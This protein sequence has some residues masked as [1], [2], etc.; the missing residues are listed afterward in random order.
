MIRS[1]LNLRQR[2]PA[3]FFSHA[4]VG[5]GIVGLAVGAE[6][7][8]N[9]AHSVIIIEKNQ[10]LCQETSS[11]NSEVIH[12]GIYYPPESLKSRSCIEGKN[13]LYSKSEHLELRRCGKYIVAQSAEQCEYLHK[14]HGLMHERVPLQMIGKQ[15]LQREQPL[16]QGASA[17]KSPSTGI[18][19]AHS[20]MN[21]LESSFQ[22]H[23][24]EIALESRVTAIEYKA[25]QE[26]TIEVTAVDGETVSLDVNNI[27]NAAGLFACQVSNLV[28]GK[29]RQIQPFYARG[30]YYTVDAPVKIDTLIYP[31]PTPGITGLGTHLTIDMGGQ[32][33]FGPDVEWTSDPND[34]KLRSAPKDIAKDVSTYMPSLANCNFNPTM[35]GIRPKLKKEREFQDFVIKQEMPGFFN[36]L[37]I[38]SPG[39]T[40]SMA[41]GKYVSKMAT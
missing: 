1:H 27:I 19:S 40:A 28:L 10:Q 8:K 30:N 26:Y 21:F 31:C 25:P 39:L 11:R 14:V 9:S 7:A 2:N 24:G 37:G 34:Y 13:L 32:V 15:Q 16:I 12:A 41:I 17:L 20:L 35:V 36:L 6:L 22:R 4:V 38:E 3:R 33:R 5:G 29:D 23:G 18:L